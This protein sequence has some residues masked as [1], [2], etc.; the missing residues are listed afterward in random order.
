MGRTKL[1]EYLRFIYGLLKG[2]TVYLRPVR[3]L[4]G[5]FFRLQAGLTA[6]LEYCLESSLEDTLKGISYIFLLYF[7]V[8]LKQLQRLY[9][10][11]FHFSSTA[12]V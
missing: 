2:Y 10:G 8:L 4:Y 11:S 3:R 9:I 7:T 12:S 5:L 1:M 6:S